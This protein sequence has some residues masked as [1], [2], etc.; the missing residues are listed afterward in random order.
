MKES[1]FALF[2]SNVH[3]TNLY[4]WVSDIA[5]FIFILRKR[6]HFDEKVFKV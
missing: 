6:H 4:L 2:L 5:E 1:K 3:E